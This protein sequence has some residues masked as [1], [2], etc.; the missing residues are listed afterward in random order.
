MSGVGE[1]GRLSGKAGR[2]V[3]DIAANVR[4]SGKAGETNG[5]A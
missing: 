2:L 4:G 3:D 5:K 1:R